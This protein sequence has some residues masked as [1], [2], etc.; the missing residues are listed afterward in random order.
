MV[1]GMHHITLDGSFETWMFRNCYSDLRSSSHTSSVTEFQFRKVVLCGLPVLP[2]ARL[3]M[4]VADSSAESHF[5]RVS[6]NMKMILGDDSSTFENEL[7]ESTLELIV[8]CGSAVEREF[9]ISKN[10]QYDDM[11]TTTLKVGSMCNDTYNLSLNSVLNTFKLLFFHST[12]SWTTTKR[13]AT[14]HIRGWKIDLIM[15]CQPRAAITY[16]CRSALGLGCCTKATKA[17]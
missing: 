9:L 13:S 11:P 3:S 1:N 8:A 6:T 16:S 15:C 12:S 7:V 4:E 10:E 5:K 14:K 2:S 17:V